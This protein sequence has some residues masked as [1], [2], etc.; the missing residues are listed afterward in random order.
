M[1]QIFLSYAR[2]DADKAQS[3]AIVLEQAGHNIWWDHHIGGG[4]QYT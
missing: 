1:A 3:L 2:S 4:S